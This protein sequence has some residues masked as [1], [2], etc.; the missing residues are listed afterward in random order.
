MSPLFS[1][2]MPIYNME[3]YLNKAVDSVLTQKFTDFELLLVNDGSTDS[4]ASIVDA[5]ATQ[6]TRVRP[7]HKPNGGAFSAYNLGI[8]EAIGKYIVIANSDD[9]LDEKAL[10]ILADQAAEYEYD[11][12]FMNISIHVCDKDQNILQENIFQNLI[13]NK[14]QITGKKEVEKSWADF[15]RTGLTQNCVNAYKSSIL[16]KHGLALDHYGADYSLHINIADDISSVSC[17]PAPLYHHFQYQYEG[18]TEHNI[19][20]SRYHDYEHNMMNNFYVDYKKLFE[21]WDVLNSNNWYLIASLRRSHLQ[22]Q[23]YNISAW[24]NK[25]TPMQNLEEILSYFD[26]VLAEAVYVVGQREAVEAE[27][28]QFCN[29]QLSNIKGLSSKINSVKNPVIKMLYEATSAKGSVKNRTKTL[30]NALFDY[31]NPYRIGLSIY[32]DFCKNIPKLLNSNELEYLLAEGESRTFLLTGK[33]DLAADKIAR[34]LDMP[35]ST[36]EKYYLFALNCHHRDLR[37]EA[38]GA[39]NRGLKEFPDYTRLK[40]LSEKIQQQ[41]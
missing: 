3:N 19:S 16:K 27:I 10:E 37:D 40:D 17:H 29:M 14:F 31:N 36:P 18:K 11:I 33:Y 22:N 13:P 15:L 24:N 4:C 7:F 32:K 8:D 30:L 12:I 5:Y 1:I 23:L 20:T 6:D 21:R 34:L 9:Y 39:I 41:E 2:V 26:D 35:V 28:I 25:M 38:T